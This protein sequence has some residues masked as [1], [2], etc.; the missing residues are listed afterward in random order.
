MPQAPRRPRSALAAATMLNLPLGS[1]YAY[2]VFLAPMERELG[3]T[4]AELSIVFAL[5]TIA[6]TAGMMGAPRLF[7][8][9][10]VPALVAA[11]AAAAAGGIALAAVARGFVE[12]ALGYG[13]MFG[14]GGGVSYIL[15]QQV[16]NLLQWRRP[17]LVNGYIVSLYPIGAMI[18]APVFGWALERFGLRATLG[19]LAATMAV[20]GLATAALIARVGVAPRRPAAGVATTRDS[21]LQR[22]VFWHMWLV[23]L[24][25][26]AAGL[27]VMSQAAGIIRAYGG[28]ATVALVGTTAITGAI[29][30]ARLTGG[31]LIDRFPPPYVMAG[32]QAFAL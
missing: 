21:A 9:A 6:F 19:G 18:A 25:A 29:A 22:F 23:F 32:A 4:R 16:V 14:L 27:T 17:G 20:T 15:V 1:L 2:S 7:G 8:R 11:C 12:L 31:W 24:L 30:A 26:A 28:A 3:L 13:L 10:P 5:A